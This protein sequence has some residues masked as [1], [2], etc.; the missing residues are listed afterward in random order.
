MMKF[1]TSMTQRSH[2]RRVYATL[3]QLDDHLLSDIGLSRSALRVQLGSRHPAE[4][5]DIRLRD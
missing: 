1:M 2:R 5:A 3:L 4:I